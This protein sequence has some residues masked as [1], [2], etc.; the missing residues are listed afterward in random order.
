[1]A[2]REVTVVEDQKRKKAKITRLGVF[3][4]GTQS[5]WLPNALLTKTDLHQDAGTVSW[6]TP[7]KNAG[8]DVSPITRKLKKRKIRN[9]KYRKRLKDSL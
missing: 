3:G 6:I 8:T 5:I 4:V 9:S 2:V 7:L 1:M